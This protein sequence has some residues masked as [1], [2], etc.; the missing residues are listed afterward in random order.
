MPVTWK[1]N[2]GCCEHEA[3]DSFGT[4]PIDFQYKV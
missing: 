4:Y 3:G 1:E 2:L